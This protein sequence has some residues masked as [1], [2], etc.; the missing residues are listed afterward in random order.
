MQ[1][2]PKHGVGVSGEALMARTGLGGIQKYPL[3]R[4]GRRCIWVDGQRHTLGEGS[5]RLKTPPWAL[6]GLGNSWPV[7][8]HIP[9]PIFASHFIV[10]IGLE[11]CYHNPFPLITHPGW[12]FP[13]VGLVTTCSD[14]M[15]RLPHSHKTVM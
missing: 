6:A 13:R 1:S 15:T 14:H 10:I 8:K 12:G 4:P 7:P 5:C 2:K 11:C 9:F 3:P